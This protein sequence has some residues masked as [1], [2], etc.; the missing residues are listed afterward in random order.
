MDF[1]QT[2][3]IVIP[4]PTKLRRGYSTATVRPSVTFLVK[5][6]QHGSMDFNQTW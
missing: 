1:D 2:L 4:L 5:T 3:Y 6:S